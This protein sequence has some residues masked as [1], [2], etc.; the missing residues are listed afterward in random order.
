MSRKSPRSR[1]NPEAHIYT[2]LMGA[3]KKKRSR[4]KL[5]RQKNKKKLDRKLKVKKKSAK[6]AVKC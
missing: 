6:D 1:K 2:H 3:E 4:N 5:L